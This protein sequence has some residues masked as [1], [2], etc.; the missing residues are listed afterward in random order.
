MT[1]I[2]VR[3]EIDRADTALSVL[4]ATALIRADRAEQHSMPDTAFVL[5]DIAKT[6]DSART[7]LGEDGPYYL[8]AAW[9]LVNAGRDR[10]ATI[11]LKAYL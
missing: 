7:R 3:S 1:S 9:A 5:R 10:L 2:L 6:L 4:I 8:D 11:S